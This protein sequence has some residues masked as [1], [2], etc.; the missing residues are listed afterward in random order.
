MVMHEPSLEEVAV[1]AGYWRVS[2]PSWLLAMAFMWPPILY[3]GID[4]AFYTSS[5]LW[6][7]AIFLCLG[8]AAGWLWWSV[9]APRWRLWAYQRVSDLERLEQLA[10]ANRLV[11][12]LTHPLTRTEVRFG[13]I[14]V[15]LGA[16]EDQIKPKTANQP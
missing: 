14:G 1:R 7:V 16:Y 10:V 4:K 2:L 12:P 11:W 8:L 9:A 3:L 15:R 13:E 6:A 5:G